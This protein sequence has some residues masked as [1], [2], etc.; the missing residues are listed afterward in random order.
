[1]QA[2]HEGLASPE[3]IR[4]ML[5]TLLEERF[6]LRTHDDRRN[7]PVYALAI[8]RGGLKVPRARDVNARPTV[9]AVPGSLGLTNATS[10]TFASQ[11]S[12]SLARPVIDQTN[13]SG[14]FD[15]ALEWTPLPGEDGGPATAGLPPAAN[16]PPPTASEGASIFTAIREQ[17]GLR[18]NPARGAVEVLVIDR[19]ERPTPD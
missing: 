10:A 12:Y 5:R 18:L 1:V 3:E 17:L 9:R 7:L 11:L 13:L 14:T 8:D 16:E 2:K 6:Q 15:F 4:Q 19:V